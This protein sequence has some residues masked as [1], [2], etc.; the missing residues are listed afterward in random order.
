MI[1][2]ILCAAAVFSGTAA[3][4]AA[5]A[6]PPGLL[7]GDQNGIYVDRYGDYFINAVG[8]RPGEVLIKTLTIRNTEQAA[9]FS[10]SMTAQPLE[11]T[12][13]IDLLDKVRLELALDGQP[14]YSG[15]L[16]GDGDGGMIQNA[17]AL[18]EYAFGGQKTVTIT[19]T[20]DKDIDLSQ[21]KSAAD[22]RWHFFAARDEAA[23]PPKTGEAAGNCLTLLAAGLAAGT[24]VLILVRKKQGADS[25]PAG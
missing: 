10:L 23:D 8:L 21:E 4:A 25:G 16:R 24:A 5:G 7:I 14:L 22:I 6:L 18:G 9:P 11:S 1:S 13:P 2:V 12:G 19:L 17:L 15:R 3:N 20:V